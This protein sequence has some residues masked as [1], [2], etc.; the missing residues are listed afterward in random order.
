MDLSRNKLVGHFNKKFS[1]VFKGNSPLGHFT[2]SF[3]LAQSFGISTDIYTNFI[4][5]FPNKMATIM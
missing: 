2:S 1:F 4:L 5:D 3:Q